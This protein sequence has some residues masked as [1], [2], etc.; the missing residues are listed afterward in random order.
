MKTVLCCAA[1]ALAV[2][3]S[4]AAAADQANAAPVRTAACNP[5]RAFGGHPYFGWIRS[6]SALSDVQATILEY[7]P[8]VDF[9]HTE[10][11]VM[12]NNYPHDPGSF[13]QWAQ[14]GWR[15][16]QDGL[17]YLWVEYT[18]QFQG[19]ND[20]YFDAQTPP[21]GSW[22]PY[23]VGWDA[24]AARL[25]YFANGLLMYQSV[26][27]FTMRRADIMAEME[28]RSNQVPGGGASHEEFYNGHVSDT[29]GSTFDFNG[30]VQNTDPDIGVA[31]QL[32]STTLDTWDYA[33][34]S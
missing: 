23:E 32:S 26:R 20:V 16:G 31:S 1:I 33:C 27:F 3:A 5:F 22:T 24:G 30:S 29:N 21:V 34:P 4:Y 14:I 17:R 7:S 12:L 2:T 15:K 10:S 6:L 8:Y 25:D 28:S 13:D 11:F 9:G 18:Y 19:W